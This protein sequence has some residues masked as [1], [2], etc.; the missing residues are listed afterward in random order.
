V[1][2]AINKLRPDSDPGLILSRLLLAL[3]L[4]IGALP[5][6][7]IVVR[8]SSDGPALSLDICH[9]AQALDTA[10]AALIPLAIPSRLAYRS[11]SPAFNELRPF[12]LHL[13]TGYIPD[14]NPPPP[15]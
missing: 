1:R 12:I 4:I 9:P 6:L 3:V 2:T 8:P 7:N 14:I 5:L 15:R 13:I 10:A 11:Q